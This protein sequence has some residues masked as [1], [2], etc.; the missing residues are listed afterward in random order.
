[1]R[2]GLSIVLLI[3][4]LL[5]SACAGTEAS[6][7]TFASS[8]RQFTQSAALPTSGLLSP[9]P[10]CSEPA[11]AQQT[12]IDFLQKYNKA[13]LDGA[14][15]MIAPDLR[16]YIDAPTAFTATQQNFPDIRKHLAEM[17]A[18]HDTLTATQVDAA[19]EPSQVLIEYTVRIPN[20][21]RT[22]STLKNG[23]KGQIEMAVRCDTL[24]LS[25]IAIET[26]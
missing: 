20:V 25:L 15:K 14:M 2:F 22:N 12:A 9:A 16:Q 17:F 4:L 19:V 3:V 8:P 5:L 18:A 23:A 13:D 21:T 7:S 1:M 24:L 10:S 26:R 6:T 11:K